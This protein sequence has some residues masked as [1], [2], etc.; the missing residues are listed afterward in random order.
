MGGKGRRKLLTVGAHTYGADLINIQWWGEKA[1]LRIGNYCSIAR[2][3]TVFLGGNHRDEW[4]STFP[5]SKFPENWPGALDIPQTPT[6]TNGNV[7]IGSDVWIGHGATIMSG[8]T[9]GHGAVI[10]ARAV[11]SRNVD[12]YAVVAGNPASVKRRRFNSALERQRLLDMAW[13]DWPDEWVAEA[14]PL[15]CRADG[16][17]DLY[18]FWE[19]KVAS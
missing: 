19:A 2:D 6:K 11:V 10:G 5:F 18:Q 17:A 9:I 12:P 1:R 15:I 14:L 16:V 13:W 3:V 8:V 7:T 4:V